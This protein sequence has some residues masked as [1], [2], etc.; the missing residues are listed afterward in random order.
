LLVVFIYKKASLNL[1]S[2]ALS[3][4]I[5]RISMNYIFVS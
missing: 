3:A 5:K 4:F 2:K 1:I